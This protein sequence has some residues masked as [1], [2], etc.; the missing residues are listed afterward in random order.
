[1]DLGIANYYKQL[2]LRALLQT[3]NFWTFYETIN[4]VICEYLR[5]SASY[6]T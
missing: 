1:M 2:A 5:K 6:L 4:I 3:S